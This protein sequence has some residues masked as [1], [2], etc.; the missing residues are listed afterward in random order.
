[1]W[2]PDGSRVVFTSDRAGQY[3]IYEKSTVGIGEATPLLLGGELKIVTDWSPD[4]RYLLYDSEDP[5]TRSDI[6]V[7]PMDEKRKPIPFARTEAYEGRGRFSP[8]GRWIAY[9]SDET[10][11]FEVYVQ[12]FPASGTKAQVSTGG[13]IEPRWRRD[14]KEL[15]FATLD[16][17]MM[18]VEVKSGPV[19]EAGPPKE[20]FPLRGVDVSTY[21]NPYAMSS[22]GQRFYMAL[23][24]EDATGAPIS[25]VLNWTAGLKP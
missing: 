25:V 18:A 14:G 13:G 21:R 3:D 7:L 1:V 19:F 22:D 2:S 23:R 12:A 9:T 5:K 11:H 15:V 17:R 24:K 4:G 20:L 8:D 6:W 16:R 10:G